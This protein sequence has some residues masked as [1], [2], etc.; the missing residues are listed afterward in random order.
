MAA[1]SVVGASDR[2][3]GRRMEQVLRVLLRATERISQ[4]PNPKI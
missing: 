3:T 2:L 4:T 1:I